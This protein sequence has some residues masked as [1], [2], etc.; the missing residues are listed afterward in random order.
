MSV[1]FSFFTWV[2]PFLSVIV[3]SRDHKGKG[4]EHHYPLSQR[5]TELFQSLEA[6]VSFAGSLME[7]VVMGVRVKAPSG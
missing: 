6:K 4:R 2:A 5:A 3:I 1:H 7:Q